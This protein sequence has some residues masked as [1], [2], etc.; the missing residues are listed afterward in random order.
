LRRARI[1]QKH[2]QLLEENQRDLAV[3]RWRLQRV[4]LRRRG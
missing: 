3:S 2:V 1:L 4:V